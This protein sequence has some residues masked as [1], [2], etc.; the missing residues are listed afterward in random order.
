M[1]DS[2]MLLKGANFLK[3][4]HWVRGTRYAT[5]NGTPTDIGSACRFCAL[6]AIDKA[7][8]ENDVLNARGRIPD[9]SGLISFNDYSAK[10]KME[11]VNRMREMAKEYKAK[12]D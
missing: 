7:C 8:S 11:V 9:I 12:G 5:M 3:N 10:N 2:E 1:K 4:H 6:G